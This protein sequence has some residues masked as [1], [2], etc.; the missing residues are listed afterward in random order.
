MTFFGEEGE[1][2]KFSI[3]SIAAFSGTDDAEL[4]YPNTNIGF[5]SITLP[6]TASL[7][8]IVFDTDNT[9]NTLR[10]QIGGAPNFY[11][12]PFF[13]PSI[14]PVS[15]SSTYTF[16]EGSTGNT[17]ILNYV[18][19]NDVS[20][21]LTVVNVPYSYN[22]FCKDTPAP[23]ITLVSGGASAFVSKSA[24]TAYD[25]YDTTGYSNQVFRIKFTATGSIIA[26]GS[27]AI[28]NYVDKDGVLQTETLVG[29]GTSIERDC[30][31]SLHLQGGDPILGTVNLKQEI[32]RPVNTQV[33]PYPYHN[34][35]RQYRLTTEFDAGTLAG[36]VSYMSGSN[37]FIQGVAYKGVVNDVWATEIPFQNQCAM[38]SIQD[39]SPPVLDPCDCLTVTFTAGFDEGTASYYPCGVFETSYDTDE[40][41][42]EVGLTGGNPNNF[43]E[44]IE[45]CLISG[46]FKTMTGGG[47]QISV[48]SACTSSLPLCN[49]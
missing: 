37:K 49:P 29:D 34:V 1:F 44:S 43:G 46:S 27:V 14:T 4:I 21:S 9:T 41:A 47:A 40:Y 8:Q 2:S 19:P 7:E 24:D 6:V 42:T 23:S 11:S 15:G 31:T 32:L 28:V 5:G 13:S 35:L 10:P 17:T 18:Q 22:I 3:A 33:T 30:Q 45:V 16:T 48:G 36:Q 26:T 20:Q 39:I 25:P 12:Q 38:V